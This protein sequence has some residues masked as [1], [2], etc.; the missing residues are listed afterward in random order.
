MG[1]I[2]K[3]KDI[4]EASRLGLDIQAADGLV[5]Y[6]QW[7]VG[8]GRTNCKTRLVLDA[9]GSG[10]NDITVPTPFSYP[11]RHKAEELIFPGYF[12]GKTDLESYFNQ[13]TSAPLFSWL[14]SVMVGTHRF[15]HVRCPFGMRTLPYFASLM[16]VFISEG[17]ARSDLSERCL[18]SRVYPR[19]ITSKNGQCWTQQCWKYIGGGNA[20]LGR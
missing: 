8:Q 9:S 16:S 17:L 20:V 10:L 19:Y 15:V 3:G 13:F 11:P 6:N 1:C 18:V 5:S 4:L 14:T 2:V 12:M 7:L